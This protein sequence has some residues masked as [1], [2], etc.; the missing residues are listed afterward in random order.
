MDALKILYVEGE[1]VWGGISWPANPRNIV[2]N[3]GRYI[4]RYDV[5]LQDL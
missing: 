3:I 1:S 4:G 2:H 5:L